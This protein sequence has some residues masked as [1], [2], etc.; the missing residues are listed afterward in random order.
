MHLV[1]IPETYGPVLLRKRAALLSAAT[2]K[3][4]R[5]EIDVIKPLDHRELVITQFKMPYIL[6]FTEPIVFVFSIYM[7]VIF[8]L[9]YMQFT[10]FPLVFQQARGWS[11]G[12]AAL[13]FIGIAVGSNTALGYMIFA[14]NPKYAAELEAKGALPPEAR[15]PT[16]LL[17]AILLPIGLFIFAW[18][19]VPVSIHWIVPIAA[20]VPYGAGLVLIFL[21]CNNY[22]IDMF[23][24]EAA[25]VLAGG[26]VVRSIMGVVLPLCTVSMYD[27]L[28]INWAS[29]LVAFLSLIFVPVPL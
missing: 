26:T 10:S 11:P 23:C 21:A 16:G 18:T 28:G 25:S 12:I 20:T 9:L 19:C 4:Y 17:G 15:L 14:G 2:G 7:A 29:T 5:S 8:G 22:L 24:H 27:A 13:A 6:L 3:V 1:F